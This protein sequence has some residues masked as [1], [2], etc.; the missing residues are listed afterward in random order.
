MSVKPVVIGNLEL[1]KIETGRFKLDGGAM[2]GVVPKT[3]WNK[4]IEADELNR[5]PMATRCLLIKSQKTDKI[6]LVDNGCGDK[7]N[8]KMTNIYSLDYNHS[9]IHRSL[10]ALDITAEDITD[11][12]FTHLHFD[13]CGG[14]TSY[15]KNGELKHNFPNATYHVNERHWQTAINPNTREKASF[16]PENINPIKQSEQLNL[17]PDRHKFEEGLTT[18]S[19]DGHTI[20]QQLPFIYDDDRSLIYTADLLP[21]F[22][23]IPLPWVMGYDMHPLQTLKEKELF[24]KDAARKSWYLYLEHDANHE[25]IRVNN[26]DGKFSVR[27]Q[28]LFEDFA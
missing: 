18:I 2:F 20:G 28:F 6:Y 1:Y 9:E 23:H 4:Q 25:I 27:D 19:A 26:Q 12:I 5:I 13:H 8:D 14:T 16:L 11:I 17:V 3:L 22:A 21:T 15:T 10:A 7:F 24:L